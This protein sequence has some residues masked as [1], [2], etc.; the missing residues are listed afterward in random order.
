MECHSGHY[1]KRRDQLA[2]HQSY[3]PQARKHVSRQEHDSVV[4]ILRLLPVVN[5]PLNL[6]R[7]RRKATPEP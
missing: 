7:A 6:A 5:N 3:F 4:G 2:D 1:S